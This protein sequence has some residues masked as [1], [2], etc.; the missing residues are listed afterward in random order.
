MKTVNIGVTGGRNYTNKETVWKALDDTHDKL[1][2]LNMNMR[3]IVGDATG[4]DYLARLWAGIRNVP[5]TV[6]EAHWGRLG[7]S[8][9]PERNKRMAEAGIAY[10]HAFKGGRGTANM[11]EQCRYRGIPIKEHE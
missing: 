3:L 7:A 6:Y 9:G 5:V 10:L 1:S 8:A 2:S 11:I 4:A